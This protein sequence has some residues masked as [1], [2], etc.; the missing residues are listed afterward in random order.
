MNIL[1][2]PSEIDQ[3]PGNEQAPLSS[4]SW[5]QQELGGQGQE[6]QQAALF[7]HLKGEEGQDDEGADHMGARPGAG[8]AQ[9]AQSD[10]CV[11]SYIQYS[12]EIDAVDTGRPPSGSSIQ[13]LAPQ[14]DG[15]VCVISQLAEEAQRPTDNQA[16]KN[17]APSAFKTLKSKRKKPLKRS[18]QPSKASKQPSANHNHTGPYVC[19]ACGKTF[20]YMYTLRTHVQAHRLDQICGICGKQLAPTENLLQHLQSHKKKKKCGVCGKQFSD[21]ARLKRHSAFHRPKGLNAVSSA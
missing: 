17:S 21:D 20:H 12:G 11:G 10:V 7:L 14:A 4:D 2:L 5:C 19:K 3:N 8:H 9:Y 18:L 1:L 6:D 15:G 16:G 13:L